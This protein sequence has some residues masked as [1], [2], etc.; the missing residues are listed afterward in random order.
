MEPGN[1]TNPSGDDRAGQSSVFEGESQHARCHWL[2]QTS[3]VPFI[4]CG[5]VLYKPGL[6]IPVPTEGELQSF[7]YDV[8]NKT[9]PESVPDQFR[10][11]C[12]NLSCGVVSSCSVPCEPAY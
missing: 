3:R 7:L 8:M 2:G 11:G 4:P 12:L 5:S 1:H 6:G 10:N 9:A